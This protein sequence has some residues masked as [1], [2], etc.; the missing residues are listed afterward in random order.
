MHQFGSYVLLVNNSLN[1]E[2]ISTA[3]YQAFCYYCQW[4]PRLSTKSTY[5]YPYLEE[6]SSA[7]EGKTE[8]VG[9]P[10]GK[11]TDTQNV[12]DITETVMEE[13]VVEEIP[14]NTQ[15]QAPWCLSTERHEVTGESSNHT[16]KVRQWEVTNESPPDHESDQ[17]DKEDKESLSEVNCKADQMEFIK[18]FQEIMNEAIERLLKKPVRR[19][20]HRKDKPEPH[21]EQGKHKEAIR[22]E[23]EMLPPR[24]VSR[25][26]DDE[27]NSRASL[28]MMDTDQCIQKLVRTEPESSEH[29]Q[30]K[31]EE[32]VQYWAA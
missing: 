2:T 22:K 6:E 21:M 26:S 13:R 23:A 3:A 31:I 20:S 1:L 32:T 27:W 18:E 4:L 8:T 12:W 29:T 5:C 30:R 25:E 10:T 7:S 14:L 28:E 16:G 17:E 11:A 9:K 15:E 19:H 24:N